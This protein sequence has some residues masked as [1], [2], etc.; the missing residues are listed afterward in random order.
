M[1][2]WLPPIKCSA[3]PPS[4]RLLPNTVSLSELCTAILL[5]R[6][7]QESEAGRSH[8]TLIWLT[9]AKNAL[10]GWAL[11]VWGPHDI[12]RR[13]NKTHKKRLVTFNTRTSWVTT[14]ILPRC[15]RL[16]FLFLSGSTEV[17]RGKN[18]EMQTYIIYYK[19][20]RCTSHRFC[21]D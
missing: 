7:R 11:N 20:A 21:V 18:E 3:G 1:H 12:K 13:S 14:W 19:L 8:R 6:A 9:E 4:L 2:F 15:L 17:T 16:L 5:L 10:V